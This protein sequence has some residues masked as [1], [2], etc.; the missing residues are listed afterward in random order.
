[1]EYIQCQIPILPVRNMEES[2]VFYR[3]LLGF[4]V[5]WIWSDNGYAAIQ[6]GEVELH[7]DVQQSFTTY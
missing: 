7:L 5:A 4:E 3:D 2:I 6:C 1:M